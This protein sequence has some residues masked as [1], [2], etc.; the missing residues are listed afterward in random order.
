MLCGKFGVL[1]FLFDFFV[2][3]IMEVDSNKRWWIDDEVVVWMRDDIVC[4][5]DYDDIEIIIVILKFLN[6]VD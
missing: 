4:E 2:F 3:K 6:L 5:I 1:W